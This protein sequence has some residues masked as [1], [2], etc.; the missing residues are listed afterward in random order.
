MDATKERLLDQTYKRLYD[1]SF[2]NHLPLDLLDEI[3]VEDVMGYGTTVDEKLFAKPGVRELIRRQREQTKDLQLQLAYTPVFRRIAEDEN[4]VV[5]ADD[6]MMSITVNNETVEMYMRFSVVFVFER[7]KWLVAHFHGSKPENVESE[8]DTFGVEE[9]KQK[10]EKLQRLVEEKTA[11]LEQKNKE[12]IVEVALERVR[13]K[14]LAMHHSDELLNVISEVAEQIKLL[15]FNIDAANFNV[16]YRKKDWDLWLYSFAMSRPVQLHV[17]W[18]NHPVFHESKKALDEDKG[19]FTGILSKQEK[20]G[21]LNHLFENTILQHSPEERKRSLLD[22]KA[23]AWS[24]VFAT[25]TSVTIANY[26]GSPYS[27]TEN[28]ILQRFSTVFE[29]SYT[30]FL[31]L[32]KAEAQTR[33][34]NIETALERVRSKAMAMQ[35][36]DEL[37]D[38]IATLSLELGRLDFKLD[39]AFIMTFDPQTKDSTWWM[40]HP[41]SPEP[42]ALK[43]QY[44]EHQPYLSHL[45]AWEERVIKWQYTLE[46]NVKKEWDKFLFNDTELL[47]LPEYVAA[48]MRSLQKV[49]FSSSFNNFG[50]LSLGTL[51]PLTDEQFDILLRFANVFDLTYTRFNDL[52]QAEAQVRE[53]Q[54]ETALERVRSRSL[55]MHKSDEL[56]AAAQ[57]LY[58][59]FGKLGIKT[60]TCGYMFID[61]GKNIQTAWAVLPDGTLLSNFITFPL[62]GDHVLNSR[63]EDWKLKKPLHV[64]E[65][66]GEV[67]KEHHQYL[68]SHVPALVVE[69]IFSKTP[70]RI[71]FHCANFSVGYLLILGEDFF[72]TEEQQ[73]IIR[74]ANV[75]EMTYT[76]FLDLQ[77]AEE[78][79]QQATAHLMQIEA[80]KQRAETALRELQATQKQLIQSE[81]MASLGELTAG[82]AH[83]IQNPLNFVNNFS[84]VN[85]ELLDELQ[86][87]INNGNID[88]VKAIANDIREN[89]IKINHHGKRADAIVKGMLQHSRKPTDKKE[90]TNINALADEYLR[91]SY[92]GLRAKDKSFNATLETNFDD[93]IEKI[94]VVPQDIGRVLLNLLTNAFYAVNEKTKSLMGS[95]QPTVWVRTF[96]V[97]DKICISVK[98]NGN[99]IPQKIL[100]KIYQP[101]FTTKPTGE[102]TGLGLSLSYDIIKAHG[103]EIKVETKKGE[104][105]EFIIRLP[106][107]D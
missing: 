105:S 41:E 102:G 82:I 42:S 39:R 74:F 56:A 32:Q 49:I 40:S 101:F 83:E 33:E 19:F 21:F 60:F 12:L 80:E 96:K 29:Q 93:S 57:L 84:D 85:T 73:T 78:H 76:R 59:E 9:W 47:K 69:E 94:N 48:N 36:S 1:V 45:K 43:V 90:A 66:Q 97:D 64:Y 17:P 63:Y 77:K 38:L 92:H 30:R 88:E 62:T 104:G 51:E 55:A 13:S 61:E 95:F 67:N 31:D 23:F 72:S 46:G 81:K 89:E 14:A 27:E 52:K 22:K 16:N 18:F 87:E 107:K 44:H 75:F 106:I 10:N 5:F 70:D 7:N 34:A 68:S 26:E 71:V 25:N 53:A 103:G 50:C 2:G 11:E 79:A 8:K 3:L 98:D 58:Q 99:G 65:I 91:L 24:T 100:D 86:A 28:A 35:N 4:S 15:G 54:I 37:K 6:I 20:D